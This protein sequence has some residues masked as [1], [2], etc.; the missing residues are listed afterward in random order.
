MSP[1]QNK[2]QDNSGQAEDVA[3]EDRAYRVLLLLQPKEIRAGCKVPVGICC[4]MSAQVLLLL[5]IPDTDQSPENE[6]RQIK[7]LN[8]SGSSVGCW[9]DSAA[10]KWRIKLPSLLYCC[11]CCFSCLLSITVS[12][13][14]W[15][16]LAQIE[17]LGCSFKQTQQKDEAKQNNHVGH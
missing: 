11:C 7:R 17:T 1:R 9:I 8:Q 2:A 3:D 5:P 14:N 12:T 15:L 10:L 4:S 16:Q 6:S 13:V